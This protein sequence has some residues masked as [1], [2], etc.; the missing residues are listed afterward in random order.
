MHI[1]ESDWST[2]EQLP[3]TDVSAVPASL[4]E[5][6][7]AVMCSVYTPTSADAGC[8]L[9][10]ECTPLR[11]SSVGAG[12]LFSNSNLS[13]PSL[14]SAVFSLPASYTA[15]HDILTLCI[16]QLSFSLNRTL[17][18]AMYPTL[19]HPSCIPHST[20]HATTANFLCAGVC[21]ECTHRVAVLS[22]AACAPMER[23]QQSTRAVVEASQ[24]RLVCYNV[25][26]PISEGTGIIPHE[27][28]VNST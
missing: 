23:R 3:L 20:L 25:L 17:Y 1:A 18:L 9:I 28:R 10:A 7:K 19:F 15:S 4:E 5:D 8:L 11:G 21:N 22:T 13:S 14:H 12:A 6:S 24:F 2:G 26:W 16:L 27:M